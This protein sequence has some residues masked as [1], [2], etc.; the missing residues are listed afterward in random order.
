MAST[1]RKYVVVGEKPTGKI[2]RQ[3]A[4]LTKDEVE[5]NKKVDDLKREK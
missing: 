5:S 4:V 1:K 2:Y 3:F